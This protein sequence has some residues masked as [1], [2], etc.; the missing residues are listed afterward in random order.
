MLSRYLQIKSELM[1]ISAS[2]T[3]F[4]ILICLLRRAADSSSFLVTP[5]PTPTLVWYRKRRFRLKVLFGLRPIERYPILKRCQF[6]SFP[7]NCILM[8][9]WAIRYCRQ[10]GRRRRRVVFNPNELQIALKVLNSS[11]AVFP[12]LLARQFDWVR[13]ITLPLIWLLG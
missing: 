3:A 5:T 10:R 12:K 2:K 4:Y 9:A 6:S 1:W 7:F 11:W 13:S 8:S